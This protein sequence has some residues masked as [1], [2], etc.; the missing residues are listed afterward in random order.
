MLLRVMHIYRYSKFP[1]VFLHISILFN[2]KSTVILEPR[3]FP[4]VCRKDESKAKRF[5]FLSY[6]GKNLELKKQQKNFRQ[7]GC[8]EEVLKHISPSYKID[9]IRNCASEP[10]EVSSYFFL[11]YPLHF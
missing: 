1:F 2:F 6:S 5:S 7:T 4:Y 9:P 8:G 11:L 3:A 10:G